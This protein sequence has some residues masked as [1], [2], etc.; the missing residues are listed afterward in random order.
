MSTVLEPLVGEDPAHHHSRR[1]TY[2]FTTDLAQKVGTWKKAG[3]VVPGI[4]NRLFVEIRH[5]LVSRLRSCFPDAALRQVNSTSLAEEIVRG[6]DDCQTGLENPLIISTCPDIVSVE[7]G[8][9]IEVNRIIDQSGQ[10]VGLGNRPGCKTID[11]QVGDFC[12]RIARTNRD[13]ILVEDGTFTGTTLLF[14]LKKFGRQIKAVVVGIAFSEAIHALRGVFDGQVYV[15][16]EMEDFIDWMPDHDFFPF[17]PNCGRVVGCRTGVEGEA[18]PS[19]H[20]CL[21]MGEVFFSVPYLMPFLSAEMMSKWTSIPANRCQE[22]SA[23][24]LGKLVE[25]IELVE[26]LNPGKRIMLSDL[27][28]FHPFIS[29]PVSVG[30]P[31]RE[32]RNEPVKDIVVRALERLSHQ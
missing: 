5:G 3:L 28:R 20:D 31:V 9:S 29:M 19:F 6:I 1:K 23:F 26:R 10:L 27:V 21:P 4:N 32:L 13:V 18:V 22:L 7:N 14:L 24:C 8:I 30:V 17:V 11:Q 16:E 2:I 12:Q 25:I 15:V